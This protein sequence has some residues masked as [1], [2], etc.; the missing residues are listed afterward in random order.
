MSA[1]IKDDQGRPLIVMKGASELVL[2][3]CENMIDLKSGDL[4]PLNSATKNEVERAISTYAKG[5]LRTIA[6]CYRYSNTYD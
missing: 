3:C 4:V 2:D 6:L 5:A 1:Y